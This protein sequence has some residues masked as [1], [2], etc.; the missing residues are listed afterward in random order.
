[1]QIPNGTGKYASKHM[2][3]SDT[4]RF[5]IPVKLKTFENCFHKINCNYNNQTMESIVYLPLMPTSYYLTSFPRQ[6]IGAPVLIICNQGTQ[7]Y[8]NIVEE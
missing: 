8:T 6:N 5:L 1:M 2:V 3:I 4:I 7:K